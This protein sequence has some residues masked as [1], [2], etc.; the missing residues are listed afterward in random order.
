MKRFEYKTV[1]I[2]PEKRAWKNPKF[3]PIRIDEVLNEM[4]KQGWELI[5]VE[6][7]KI[8]YGYTEYFIYTFKRE[9]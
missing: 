4:G 2:K 3:D 8:G 6:D 1:E 9:I 7:K 5:A